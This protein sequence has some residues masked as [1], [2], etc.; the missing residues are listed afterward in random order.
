MYCIFYNKTPKKS[1]GNSVSCF[2]IT[3]NILLFTEFFTFPLYISDK[4]C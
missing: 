1:I 2:Y 4:K 3:A